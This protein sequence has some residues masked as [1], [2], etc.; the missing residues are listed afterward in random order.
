MIYAPD[1]V[2]NKF[3]EW[4]NFV[5]DHPNNIK[6]VNLFIELL[7]LIRKDMGNSKS[8]LV[9]IVYLDQSCLPPKNLINLRKQSLKLYFNR[10]RSSPRQILIKIGII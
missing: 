10:K 5:G 1:K 4:N 8:E 3:N 9:V 6:H 2:L 7:I